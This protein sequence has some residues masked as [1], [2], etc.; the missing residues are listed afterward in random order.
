MAEQLANSGGT[1]ATWGEDKPEVKRSDRFPTTK[2]ERCNEKLEE[3]GGEV[4]SLKDIVAVAQHQQKAA[5][6]ELMKAFQ[7]MKSTSKE[8]G[9]P[10]ELVSRGGVNN[11]YAPEHQYPPRNG[12]MQRSGCYY[13]DGQDHYSKECTVK[14]AHIHKG[15]ITVEDGQQRL[16]DGS[17]IPRGR[18]SP[19]SHVEEYWQRKGVTGQHMLSESFYGA[20]DNEIDSLRDE[21]RCERGLSNSTCPTIVH[22]GIIYTAPVDD[23]AS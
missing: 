7:N 1:E 3:L 2:I 10:K 18:G 17:Y 6:E 23:P 15:W 9:E 8:E 22:S 4:S 21:I 20:A 14:A 16:A 12:L 5:H 19:A 11:S 13:S